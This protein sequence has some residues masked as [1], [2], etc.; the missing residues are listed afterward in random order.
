MNDTTTIQV[1]KEQAERLKE[2]QEPSGNYK[3]ALDTV[4]DSYDKRKGLEEAIK[5]LSE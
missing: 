1:R 2:I 4:I 3:T 5:Q